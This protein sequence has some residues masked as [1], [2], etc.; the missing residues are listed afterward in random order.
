MKKTQVNRQP[1][2]TA[3]AAPAGITLHPLEVYAG[4]VQHKGAPAHLIL[5]PGDVQVTGIEAA[6]EFVAS[7]GGELPTYAELELLCKRMSDRFKPSIYYTSDQEPYDGDM[8]TM[9]FDFATAHD[10]EAQAGA[11]SVRVRA[12]RRVPTKAGTPSMPPQAMGPRDHA[13]IMREIADM[14]SPVRIERPQPSFTF[15][16]GELQ[17]GELYAGIVGVGG[18]FQ[19]LILLPAKAYG[20]SWQQAKTFAA[21]VGGELPDLGD[22]DVLLQNLQQEFPGEDAYWSSEWPNRKEAFYLDFEGAGFRDLDS[23]DSL[24]QARAV[25]RIFAG[26]EQSILLNWGAHIRTMRE[27]AGV[28]VERL[29]V[30]MSV[31]PD[32]IDRWEGGEVRSIPGPVLAEVCAVLNIDAGWL[33]GADDE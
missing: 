30:L 8:A 10:L 21:A 13:D 3:P 25:R 7:V 14:T 20:V 15:N 16:E 5:M 19:H 28:T 6:E 4:I 11:R 32:V 29:A 18:T 17:P 1:A 9:M 12:V 23:V 2:A 27:A 24:M 26:C 22:F 33:L 31:T